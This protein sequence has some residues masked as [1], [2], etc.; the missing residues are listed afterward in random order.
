MLKVII[1]IVSAEDST[2]M[3]TL[4]AFLAFAFLVVG[5]SNESRADRRIFGFTYSYPTLPKGSREI[6]H[7]L[8]MGIL[9]EAEVAPE[10]LPGLTDIRPAFRHQLEFEYGITDRLDLGFYNVFRQ[11]VGEPFEYRGI[12]LRSRYRF[13][14]EGDH[15]VDIGVYGEI[16]YFGDA[17]GFEERL[18]VSKAVRR[19]QIDFNLKLEQEWEL[20]VAEDRAPA[21]CDLDVPPCAITGGEVVSEFA[22]AI[23]PSLGLGYHVRDWIAVGVELAPE[24]EIKDGAELTSAFGPTVSLMGSGFWWTIA[25]QFRVHPEETSQRSYKDGDVLVRSLLGITL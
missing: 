16:F 8:D 20:E 11:D 14:E 6:E 25:A 19:I 15:P 18:I 9:P 2:D 21:G 23:V 5:L 7:Y 24:I 22:L 3:R 13:G 4:T 1:N 12:K 17:Y 10:T